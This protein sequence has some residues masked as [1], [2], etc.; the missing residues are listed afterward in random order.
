MPGVRAIDDRRRAPR[1]VLLAAIGAAHLGAIWWLLSP[2]DPIKPA[3]SSRAISLFDVR[4]PIVDPETPPPPAPPPPPPPSHKAAVR[5]ASSGGSPGSRRERAAVR[6]DSFAS[7]MREAM[8]VLPSTIPIGS[9]PAL[10]AGTTTIDL[11]A[12]GSDGQGTGNGEG[13]GHGDGSGS[14]AE[15]FGRAQWVKRPPAEVFHRHWPRGQSR[16]SREVVVTLSCSVRRSGVPYRCRLRREQ[17]RGLGFARTALMVMPDARV[18]P[19]SRNGA[20]MWDQ[21]V[22]ITI[23]FDALEVAPRIPVSAAASAPRAR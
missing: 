1:F 21:P 9:P 4:A 2:N 15:E 14:G 7:P 20:P 6:T 17:P 8:D 3:T 12:G 18:L 10:S 16:L 13:L 23:V 11:G 5:P 22:L 19:M